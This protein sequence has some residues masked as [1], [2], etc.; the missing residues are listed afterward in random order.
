M[1]KTLIIF[2]RYPQAGK[3]KTRLIPALGAEGAAELQRQMTEHTL[4]TARKLKSG[5]EID[6]E[7]HFTGGNNQLMAEWLGQN[8]TYI[9][10]V[11]GGLG[12]KMRSAFEGA[13]SS[14]S[15]RVVIIGIDCPDLD[16]SILEEAFDS[17]SSLSRKDLVIG[18]AADGGYYLIGSNCLIPQL[19]ENMDWGTARVLNQTMAIANQ[20]NL[21]THYLQ[22]LSDVDRPEDLA[23][24]QKY[25]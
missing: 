12:G 1:R 21:N 14:G 20:L 23:I 24:W 18:A 7:V 25:I 4:K 3:T 9:P 6:V 19:L 5:R 13:F 8:I 11:T 17:L 22:V 2:S 16:Q 10:Q 15:K